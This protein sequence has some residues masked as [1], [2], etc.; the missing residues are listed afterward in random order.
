MSEERTVRTEE[1]RLPV[2]E[3]HV[4]V[5]EGPDRGRSLT[6]ERAIVGVGSAEDNQLILSD[7]TV[8]RYHLELR[9]LADQIQVRD[10]GS[11]NGTT[12]GNVTL[13]GSQ[14]RLRLPADI[15]LGR[16]V[17]RITDGDVRMVKRTR[18]TSLGR[19][20]TANENMVRVLG[21]VSQVSRNAAPVLLLGESGVGKEL[22]AE[23][24]HA[25]SDRCEG[26][27]VTVDCGA[28]SPALFASELFGHEKGAFPGAVGRP[29]G[30]FE[31]ADGGTLFLDEIGELPLEQQASLLGVLERRR[32]R[33]VGGQQELE[34]NIRVIS[35]T[36]RDLREEVN[37][38][39]FRLDLYYR[40][41]VVL[42]QIPPLRERREDIT[43]LVA[44]FLRE[45]GFDG[46]PEQVFPE[47]RLA[48]LRR[49]G[50]PGNVRELKNVVIATL[51][52]G[53][54]RLSEA[55]SQPRFS[56][57]DFTSVEELPPYRAARRDH[58]D[59]FEVAYLE[60]LLQRAEGSVRKAAR[61]AKMDRS[62][63]TEL[64]RRH[65]LK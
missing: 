56:A 46:P 21:E 30:A 49:H 24:I 15:A 25:E 5:M 9:R 13:E 7:R 48:E 6:T 3:L 20:E 53:V 39:T 59:A 54:T 63:L 14:A 42:L 35:A 19:L 41:G 60:A 29:R 12:M 8:S 52:T 32:F 26:P 38:G 17:I 45:E 64:L 11:T 34:T 4:T 47:D 40:V 44:Q 65:G 57:P 31:R 37:R 22:V 50:W 28:I 51:A 16:S 18:V 1:R 23:T 55:R 36:N 27:F 10:L 33:R 62:Y 2:L 58:T 43:G 61:L